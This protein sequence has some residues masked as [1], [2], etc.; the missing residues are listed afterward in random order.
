MIQ[1]LLGLFIG[2]ILGVFTLSLCIAA[3]DEEES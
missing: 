1:F 2:G 3:K